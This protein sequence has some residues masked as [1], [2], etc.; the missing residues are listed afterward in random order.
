MKKKKEKSIPE[1]AGDLAKMTVKNM[2]KK[3]MQEWAEIFKDI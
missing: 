1:I 3:E 2:S